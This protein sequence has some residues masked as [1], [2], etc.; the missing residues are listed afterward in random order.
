MTL[1]A[2]RSHRGPSNRG[3][4]AAGAA[5]LL[6]PLG[7]APFGAW[8][9]TLLLL[10]ALMF[11]CD[12]RSPGEAARRGFCFGFAAFA[13]GAYWLYISIHVFGGAPVIIAFVLMLGLFVLMAAYVAAAAA[14]AA[15]LSGF[16]PALRWCVIWP[17]A[18]TLIEWLRGTLFTGFPWLTLGYGQID[19]PLAAWAPV[20]GVHGLSLVTLVL[21][22]AL[23]SLWRGGTVGRIAAAGLILMIGVMTAGLQPLRWVEPVGEPVR[24]SMVQGSIPQDR[25]WR[26][27]Q[28]E[29]TLE[30]YRSLTA[31]QQADLV[32]WPEVA[33]PA[34]AQRVQ[35]FLDAVAADARARGQQVY[36]GILTFD[37]ERRQYRNSLI[38]IGRHTEAYHKRHLVPFGEFFPVPD[39]ARRW[40]R[41]AGL[42]NQDT[43]AGE[44]N[45]APLPLG[46]LRLAPTICYEDAYGAE[47]LGFLP[48]SNL[49][50]NVSNDA[51]FGGSIAPHQHLQIARMRALET[52]RFMLRATNT[53]ITAII[54][55]RGEIVARSPQFRTHVLNGVVQ[56]YAGATPYVRLGD[57][58]VLLI[59]TLLIAGLFLRQRFG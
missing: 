34:L 25:K 26:P 53:G 40:M 8:P 47:Q 35:D 33:V 4:W 28:L 57:T 50:I 13:A 32:I 55:P 48:A 58:P 49:L 23:L 54:S 46:T 43:L 1:P 38:G 15:A 52:G 19:G 36:L 41:S 16:A 2:E 59:C 12:G 10:A 31:A 24:V 42:P 27:E 39:F 5:G 3:R 11:L 7:F 45:Q 56:P 51:W 30:L 29:P 6:L 37:S 21:S 20:A 17:A 18:F 14:V 22:G 9:V 44:K